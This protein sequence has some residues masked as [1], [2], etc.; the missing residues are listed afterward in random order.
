MSKNKRKKIKNTVSRE[1]LTEMLPVIIDLRRAIEIHDREDLKK[2]SQLELLKGVVNYNDMGLF[3]TYFPKLKIYLSTEAIL[4]TENILTGDK[5]IEKLSTEQVLCCVT[6][7]LEY[8][9]NELNRDYIRLSEVTAFTGCLKFL[10][11]NPNKEV[12]DWALEHYEDFDLD[13]VEIC[14]TVRSYQSNKELRDYVLNKI[15]LFE[16]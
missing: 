15:N 4:K 1:K 2:L 7:T 10:F 14:D 6:Q 13:E 12:I 11:A 3:F 5:R 9:V 8:I 16:E